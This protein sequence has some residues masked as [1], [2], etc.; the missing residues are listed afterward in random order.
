MQTLLALFWARNKEYYR[1]R[2]SLA[3]SFIMPPLIIGIISLALGGS[4]QTLFKVGVIGD[5]Q[6]LIHTG[7]QQPFIQHIIV[8]DS[9]RAQRR[10]SHH[11]LDLLIH[12]TG[13][14]ARYWL[15]DSNPR[16]LAVEQLLLGQPSNDKP[17]AYTLEK[18]AVSGREVRYIDWVL[19]G[20]LGMNLMFSG[21]FGIGYVIVRYRKN[22]VL[23]RLQ[24]TPI[25]PLQFLGAHILSRLLIM[26]MVSCVIYVSCDFFLDFLM[27]GSYLNLLLVAL[28]GNLAIL[29]LG[30]VIA[31]RLASEELAN[32][33][34]NFVS[35]PMLLLSEVW[36]SL[37]GAP[38]WV[39]SLSNWLPLTHTVQAARA[40]MID[41][42]NLS[43]ISSHLLTLAVMTTV[44]LAI[45]AKLFRWRED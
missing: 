8:E 9:E 27:L 17:A 11:Q 42:S 7:L 35:F 10:V 33:L 15:N 36:F 32:G 23:K 25:T 16:S 39:V 34:L 41:G 13:S 29:S 31:S 28:L 40:V 37:D 30:L 4:S 20:V 21:L 22:G 18:Q 38:T 24:A 2:G 5:A 3:W 44:L 12:P 26:L 1:D 45:A 14:G 6:Q 43:D 19:P